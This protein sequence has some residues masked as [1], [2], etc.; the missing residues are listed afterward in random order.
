MPFAAM[1]PLLSGLETPCCAWLGDAAAKEAAAAAPTAI[2]ACLFMISS[3]GKA[4][5]CAL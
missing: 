2:L 1:Y 3:V 4:L 5:E